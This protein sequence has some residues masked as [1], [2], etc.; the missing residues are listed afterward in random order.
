[1]D[2]NDAL[3][4]PLFKMKPPFP[5]MHAAKIRI[6]QGEK[7]LV[8]D[9]LS[10]HRPYDGLFGARIDIVGPVIHSTPSQPSPLEGWTDAGYFTITTLKLVYEDILAIKQTGDRE[11]PY[12]LE[13][14]PR[15]ESTIKPTVSR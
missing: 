10:Y 4:P 2:T 9:L 15:I 6:T 7:E 11:V 12:S 3:T 13:L 14:K 8:G 5:D 1:M